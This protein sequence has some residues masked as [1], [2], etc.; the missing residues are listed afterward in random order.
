MEIPEKTGTKQ[1]ARIGFSPQNPEI[2]DWS[3]FLIGC[4]REDYCAS[5]VAR[6]VEDCNAHLLNLN[7]V[8]PGV[9]TGDAFVGEVAG[10]ENPVQVELC[11]NHRDAG[12][13]C[14]SLERYGFT[15]LEYE[16]SSQADNDR[17]LDNYR[18]LM[19]YLEV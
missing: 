8:R 3:R 17:L 14:R 19:H 5:V 1:S 12:M 16:S 9:L 4:R 10:G 11:V 13:V 2:A 6:A 18:N 15:V 7:V